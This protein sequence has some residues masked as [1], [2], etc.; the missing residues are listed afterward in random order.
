[1]DKNR[2]AVN[3]LPLLFSDNPPVIRCLSGIKKK[4]GLFLVQSFSILPFVLLLSLT[5]SCTESSQR[6]GERK[7]EISTAFFGETVQKDSFWSH[8][9]TAHVLLESRRY[10]QAKAR[11]LKAKVFAKSQLQADIIE[12]VYEKINTKRKRYSQVTYTS[13]Q[14]AY[15]D[16]YL[17]SLD[18]RDLLLAYNYASE[19]VKDQIENEDAL[20]FPGPL[21]KRQHV[22]FFNGTYSIKSYV[23]VSKSSGEKVRGQFNCEIK[24]Y[25]DRKNYSLESLE[26]IL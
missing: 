19:Y 9:D 1:M 3:Y 17:R 14:E 8:I 24:L 2:Y 13:Y 5:F 21:I 10:S 18:I 7:C 26:I 11:L 20:E 6:K 15:I 22:V 25:K 12:L 23:D 4:M 16:P